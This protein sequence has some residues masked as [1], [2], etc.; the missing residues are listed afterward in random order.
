MKVDFFSAD[1]RSV[2]DMCR[3]GMRP[4]DERELRRIG[5]VDP[6]LALWNS[7]QASDIAI[8]AYTPRGVACLLGVCR[9]S[10]LSAGAANIWLLAHP[11]IERYSVRFLKECR[12]VLALLLARYGRLEN[13]ID[14]DNVKTI[15]WLEWLGFTVEKTRIV[16]SP[17]G[18]PFHH[19]WKEAPSV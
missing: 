9:P 10:L 8:A 13:H 17:M 14:A 4:C 2:G 16:M 12:R 7:V 1:A 15:A 5:C 11:D 3:R 19:F 6:Y 18:F